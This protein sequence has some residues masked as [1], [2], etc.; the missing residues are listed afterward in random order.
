MQHVS[1]AISFCD[2][3]KL[4]MFSWRAFFGQDLQYQVA[5]FS[6]DREQ[7]IKAG[8]EKL[9]NAKEVLKRAAQ[10]AREKEQVRV[11]FSL[12]FYA[13]FMWC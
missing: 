11:N 7:H 3:H 8:Q 5:T 10:A 1:I 12:F 6:R 13:L 2:I 4:Q 9:K